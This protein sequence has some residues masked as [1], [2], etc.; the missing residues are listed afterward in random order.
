MRSRCNL[1]SIGACELG[2]CFLELIKKILLLQYSLCE[3][4]KE[5]YKDIVGLEKAWCA[6]LV[7]GRSGN[8]L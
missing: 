5:V 1:N 3:N 7:G 2:I 8:L 4:L 6:S